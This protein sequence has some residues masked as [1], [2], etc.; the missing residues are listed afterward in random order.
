[1]NAVNVRRLVGGACAI[2]GILLATAPLA[3]PA[4][5]ATHDDP[6]DVVGR[7]DLR[8]VTRTFTN[9]PAAPPFV[10][11]Q[12]ETYDRWTLRQ[13]RRAD[14]C[15]FTFAF[16]TRRGPGTD[17]IAAWDADPSGPSCAVFGTRTG[18]KLG[19]GDAAKFRHS[20]FCSFHK[21]LL[22]AEGRVRW[23]VRSL[24]GVVD[25]AAPDAGWF[26]AR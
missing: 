14:A 6:D 18:R 3:P 25:D 2:L 15:S 13:C 23:R 20:A 8:R 17:V 26:G 21:A 4:A 9:G 19:E 24:W 7:L 12:A 1:M 10:H 22:G 11:M 5:A 16:D